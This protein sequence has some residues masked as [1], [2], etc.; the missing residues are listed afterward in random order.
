MNRRKKQ[1]VQ[2][3]RSQ[4]VSKLQLEFL[5]RYFEAVLDTFLAAYPTTGAWC[6]PGAREFQLYLQARQRSKK[7]PLP[8]GLLA[9]DLTNQFGDEACWHVAKFLSDLYQTQPFGDVKRVLVEIPDHR[10]N[11]LLAASKGP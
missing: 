6:A 3:Q 2:V 9:G 5:R 8:S 7:P 1:R 10:Y 11:I 4:T